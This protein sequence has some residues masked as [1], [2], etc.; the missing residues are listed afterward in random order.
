MRQNRRVKRL[1]GL[2][3]MAGFFYEIVAIIFVVRSRGARVSDWF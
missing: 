1:R 2:P 3:A